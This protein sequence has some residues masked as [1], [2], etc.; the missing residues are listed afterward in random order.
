MS[1]RRSWGL[2]VTVVV[3]LLA[4]VLLVVLIIKRPE[5][6]LPTEPTLRAPVRVLTVQP[7][8]VPDL[9]TL[10][11]RVTAWREA[12]LAGAR[13]GT[14][15]ALMVEKGDRVQAGQVLAQ[16]D[17]RAWEAAAVR[18]RS[19]MDD[20]ARQLARLQAL[21]LE[22]AV[23][24]NE[25]DTAQT[26]HASALAALHEAE[27]FRDQCTVTAPF[28]GVIN[29]RAVDLGE[30][31]PE[32]GRLYAL[33][34]HARVKVAVDVPER[35]VAMLAVETPVAF[36][37]AAIGGETFTGRVCFVAASAAPDS[38]AFRVD[39]ALDNAAGRLRPGML[40]DVRLPRGLHRAAVV[41]PLDAVL[42]MKGEHVVFV[43]AD[44]HA[45]RR[46]VKI[47]AIV[48]E[49]AVLASGVTPG[50]AVII[51]GQRSLAD[52]VLVDVR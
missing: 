51:E 31:V 10:P 32:G 28:D 24:S 6:V 5:E 18:A 27:T 39:L 3:L 42:P 52:G 35:D 30:Y 14:I 21:V 34:D 45:L 47:A 37:L 17:A 38:N 2:I 25:V 29:D 48:G 44:G 13:A 11:G 41:V 9:L 49:E 15:M 19:E 4:I 12:D 20:A 23:S 46:I 8:D 43:A 40:A 22:G 7:R 36:T 1:E 33:V 16:I 26:R 50:E